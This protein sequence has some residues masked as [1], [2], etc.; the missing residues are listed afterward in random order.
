VTKQILIQVIIFKSFIII[1]NFVTEEPKQ[2]RI[3]NTVL[4]SQKPTS[5]NINPN[6]CFH[7]Q[8][9]IFKIILHNNCKLCDWRTKTIADQKY[10]FRD[11]SSELWIQANKDLI[12]CCQ[13]QKIIY[14]HCELC[15]KEIRT[16]TDPEHHFQNHVGIMHHCDVCIK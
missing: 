5:A 10:H 1:A 16:E 13:P 6:Y 4:R 14:H 9:V 11:S 7:A 15:N 3:K 8:K 12:H 2:I